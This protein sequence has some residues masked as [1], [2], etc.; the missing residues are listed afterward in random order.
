MRAKWTTAVL[1][2]FIASAQA[3]AEISDNVVRI[4]VLTDL[5]SVYAGNTGP[6]SV[7]AARMAIEDFG[8][9]ILGKPIELISADHQN[10]PDIGTALARRWF[11]DQKVDAI[12]D[13][14]TSSIALAVQNLAMERGKMLLISGAGSSEIT[15][16]ACSPTGFQWTYDSFGQSK[17]VTDAIVKQGLKSWFF[18]TADYAFGRA[19]EQDARAEL[20]KIGATVIGG[21]RHPLN[22][23]D[24]SSFIL[25]AKSSKA[26]VVVLANGGD[27]T[28]NAIKQA[29]EFGLPQSGQHIAALQSDVVDIRAMGLDKAKGLMLAVAW[30]WDMNDQTRAFSKRFFD[31]RKVMPGYIHAGVYSAVSTYLQ[32][33]KATESDDAKVVAARM[34][35]VRIN[36]V[37]A[38]NGQARPDG[39]MVH[40]MYLVRV[41]KPEESKN[42]WD[43]FTIVDTV[44]GEQAFRPLTESKC[45]LV[46]QGR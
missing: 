33:I 5:S 24:F 4:G 26:A 25:Q 41:K 6:G 23:S 43:V 27:D 40:D 3:H 21:V 12:V 9:T 22:T 39:R 35:S 15:N 37:F 32:A 20:E 13:V 2:A 28:A 42:E 44:P 10:K 36:D 18:V 16:S 19:L 11:D 1:I 45:P 14:P 7:E 17:V 38:T 29:D 30:Y 31:R 8:G 46:T 34:K